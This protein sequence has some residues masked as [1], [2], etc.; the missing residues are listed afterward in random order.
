MFRGL[1]GIV[2][3][4]LHC[5]PVE[6]RRHYKTIFEVATV[7]LAKM[8]ACDMFAQPLK[9]GLRLGIVRFRTMARQPGH[10]HALACAR[11]AG[12]QEDTVV[13]LLD[14]L[15]DL[16][17]FLEG[18]AGVIPHGYSATGLSASQACR[19]PR[20]KRLENTKRITIFPRL[21][22]GNRWSVRK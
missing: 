18:W 4:C 5:R 1:V 16:G 3:P 12:K 20:Q 6:S 17:Q 21:S 13:G 10:N 14:P 7:G 2:T 22:P 9:L 8:R 11:A 19:T 15:Q